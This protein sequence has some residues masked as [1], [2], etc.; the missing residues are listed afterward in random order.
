MDPVAHA[1]KVPLESIKV[2]PWPSENDEK[3][4][5][6]GGNDSTS[7]DVK[8]NDKISSEAPSATHPT[9][10]KE[11]DSS[12]L[13]TLEILS[14]DV[15]ASILQYLSVQEISR[16]GRV[17]KSLY[18]ASRRSEIWKKKF[19]ARWNYK[20]SSN[21]WF[22][23]YQKAY[24][25]TDD[26]WVTH[27]NIVEPCDGLGVGRCCIEPNKK[28][29]PLSTVSPSSLC[30]RCRYHPSIHPTAYEYP[31]TITNEAQAIASATRIRLAQQRQLSNDY[32]NVSPYRSERAEQ[33]FAKSATLHR[34]IDTDQYQTASLNFVRDLLFFQT[35][36][37]PKEL[38][39]LK[40]LYR[41][42]EFGLYQVDEASNLPEACETA[43][44][45]WHLCHFTNPD[46]ERPLVWRVSIMR[47]DCFTVYPSEGASIFNTYVFLRS[48]LHL[49]LIQ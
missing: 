46:Y 36:E 27:W 49:G 7:S 31:E 4:H 1:K 22:H 37:D 14:P 17:S 6:F 45:S 10:F 12:M 38:D 21:D 41:Q 29:R 34:A 44:H 15:S 33:A 47:K 30:P 2:M 20:C 39:D 43:L 23:A 19:E 32:A 25:N 13:T 48:D 40:E 5:F 42:D 18:Q 8:E 35:H 9:F 11:M 28:S 16:L 24:W 3:E 26:L